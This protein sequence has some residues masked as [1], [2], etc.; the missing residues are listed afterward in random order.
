VRYKTRGFYGFVG[1]AE[2]M[3]RGGVYLLIVIIALFSIFFSCIRFQQKHSYFV[4]EIL[5]QNRAGNS[6][7][8]G[9]F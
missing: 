7:K 9:A 1:R 6:F 4:W 3:I 2:G 8:S 5:A